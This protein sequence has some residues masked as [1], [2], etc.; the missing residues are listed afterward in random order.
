[1]NAFSDKED[2]CIRIGRT[3]ALLST[4]LEYKHERSDSNVGLRDIE[5]D[6][7]ITRR[8]VQAM[9][10]PILA[11]A[12]WVTGILADRKLLRVCAQLDFDSDK[13]HL[14]AEKTLEA[15]WNMHGPS[16][17]SLHGC[18][19]DDRVD[20]LCLWLD[21]LYGEGTAARLGVRSRVKE[22]LH[23]EDQTIKNVAAID[24]RICFVDPLAVLI[25][26]L[27]AELPAYNKDSR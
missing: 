6:S 8:V 5:W 19:L 18:S 27:S 2:K 13:P 22:T 14:P 15:L 1:M 23:Q 3:Y 17:K 7:R 26:K 21:A 16:E 20:C 12:G 25:S 4:L 10:L 9:A 24:A 11:F